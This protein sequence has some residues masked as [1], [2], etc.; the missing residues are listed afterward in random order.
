MRHERRGD[1][2]HLK[3][4]S[5]NIVLK[6]SEPDSGAVSAPGVAQPPEERPAGAEGESDH[7]AEGLFEEFRRKL[8]ATWWGGI[9]IEPAELQQRLVHSVAPIYPEV[10]RA[11][12]M[13]GDVVLRA[14]VSSDGRV[15]SLKVVSGAP[16]LA[17]AAVAAV[18][19]WRY[20][21][22]LMRG[23]PVNVVTTL[24]VAFRLQ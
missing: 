19:Q 14:Y 21:P 4:I 22:V 13:E 15:A 7:A 8:E 11:A 17:R 16:V 24:T 1:V 20:K 5:G 6:V 23:R 9:P 2:L 18:Q 3:A 10:A 12:G